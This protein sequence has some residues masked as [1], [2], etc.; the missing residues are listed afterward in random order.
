MSST[1]AAAPARLALAVFLL[2][3]LAAL[4]VVAGRAEGAGRAWS[5][6]LAPAAACPGADDPSAAAAAQRRALACLL[7][8]ARAQD[9]RVRLAASR[10]LARA[11]ALKGRRLV[12]CDEVSHSPCGADP[13]AALRAAGYRPA[14]FGE[15]LFVGT[16]GAVSA[17]DVAAAWF[18]SPPHRANVL[19]REF[20]EVGVALVRS[21]DLMGG[22]EAVVWIVAFASP[23]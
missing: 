16:W 17:R 22:G 4:A 6:Y 11:A 13:T 10:P 20:R 8:W 1:T 23:R 3:S 2:A 14:S 19:R 15:N 5:A 21:R 18:R 9:G 12:S 7:N